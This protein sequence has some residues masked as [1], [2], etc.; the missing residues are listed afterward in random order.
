MH[1]YSKRI[2][3]I[4]PLMIIMA[5]YAFASQ[6]VVV[7]AN[8][9]WAS[10]PTAEYKLFVN[11]GFVSDLQPKSTTSEKS[12]GQTKLT[13]NSIDSILSSE[14]AVHTWFESDDGQTW[15]QVAGET[16]N[17]LE[18]KMD[19]IGTRRYQLRDEY[20]H[21]PLFGKKYTNTYYST[22]ATINVTGGFVK[23]TSASVNFD[24]DYLLNDIG[25]S[26]LG[27][28]YAHTELT[29]SNS[30]AKTNWYSNDASL[31]TVDVNTGEIT[32]N[33]KRK[34]GEVEIIAVVQ[35]GDSNPIKESNYIEIGG[36]LRDQ[37][38]RVGQ[39]ADFRL[40]PLDEETRENNPIQINWYQ[41]NN[42][43][44]ND[45]SKHVVN[46]SN[47]YEYIIKNVIKDNDGESYFATIKLG[48]DQKNSYLTN[49]AKLNVTV[50][51]D[52]KVL[53][54]N[55]IS[56]HSDYRNNNDN[57]VYTVNDVKKGDNIVYHFS[58]K[59]Y[60]FQSFSDSSMNLDIPMGTKVNQVKIDNKVVGVDQYSLTPV[61]LDKKQNL[62][63]KL[64]KF[65]V[66]EASTIDIDTNLN[67]V[68]D[69][70]SFVTMPY[71]DGLA[72]LSD[73]NQ[74][75]RYQANGLQPYTINFYHEESG[76]LTPNIKPIQFE[77]II[78]MQKNVIDY[79]T[80]ATNAPNEIAT[81][82]DKR[83]QKPALKVYL[84]EKAPLGDSNHKFD[85]QLMYYEKGQAPKLIKDKVLV[86]TSED[87]QPLNP[88]KWDRNTGLLLR[89]KGFNIPRGTY[90]TTLNWTFENSIG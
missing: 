75:K 44:S 6:E 30:T 51:Y 54:K 19:T 59:N 29:P 2:I 31:A 53:V 43:D 5:L 15:H 23:A 52:P 18:V 70:K 25:A 37:N 88:I 42:K 17:Y 47:P 80:A 60:G 38:L 21:N 12:N 85:G 84:Q 62:K 11:G 55:S 82:D 9:Q 72:N 65:D 35:N 39:T 71:F 58:L 10:K 7:S 79:R 90:Q 8:A 22:V 78:P 40:L 14:T 69:R 34:S 81:F 32:A 89:L 4:L 49:T 63:I 28:T 46:Q 67:D 45:H 68:G 74:N 20:H 24:S 3:F 41:S 56:N 26:Y 76:K 57:T 33:T 36:G 27:K 16:K 77:T 64:N 87:G 13:V 48:D 83:P 86:E 66:D 61:F 1:G 73:Y 50:P